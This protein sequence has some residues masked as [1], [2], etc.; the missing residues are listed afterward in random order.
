MLP[1]AVA[2]SSDGVA[3]SYVLPVSRMRLCFRTMGQR[4]EQ[5]SRRLEEFARWRYQLDI[6]QKHR[7]VVFVRMRRYRGEVCFYDCPVYRRKE[8][9]TW[10]SMRLSWAAERQ[11]RA[12]DSMIGV[13]GNPTT[14]TAIPR[15]RHS[16]PN[17]LKQVSK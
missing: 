3:I 8:A 16:R 15:F 4:A 2:R 7:S 1:V 13:A 12:R 10:S 5:Y 17:A 11:K 6:R 9:V 14:T